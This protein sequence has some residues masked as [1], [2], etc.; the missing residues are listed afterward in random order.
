MMDLLSVRM[1]SPIQIASRLGEA[2][3]W[4]LVIVNNSVPALLSFVY[5]FI[6]ATLSWTPPL[7]V[8]KKFR[9]LESYS[10]L[11][12]FLIGF[13]G[14]GAALA[15]GWLIGGTHLLTAL[16][17]G[18]SVHG[19]IEV[20]T[21]LLCVSE[22]MRLASGLKRSEFDLRKNLRVDLR[23]LVVSMFLLSVAAAIEVYVRL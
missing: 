15:M 16:L 17:L 10:Y 8:E 3:V 5:V 12:A 7:S 4:L 13:F 23:L 19:P 9:L 2:Y 20:T 14:F 11:C 22:P 1:I 6:L 18:A 21:V